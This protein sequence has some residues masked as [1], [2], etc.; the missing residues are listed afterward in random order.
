MGRNTN[1]CRASLLDCRLSY[2]KNLPARIGSTHDKHCSIP[3]RLAT[4]PNN[5][6]VLVQ[7]SCYEAL[8]LMGIKPCHGFVLACVKI[9]EI[10]VYSGLGGLEIE[11]VR[12][13]TLHN[14][15][16]DGLIPS[17]VRTIQIVLI[18]AGPHLEIRWQ[19]IGM[20]E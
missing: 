7:Q 6:T 4:L 1:R 20:I 5:Y 19:Q 17:G 16:I 10:R 3:V 8:C 2:R 15:S 18:L 9:R 13:I 11:D 14:L 12:I